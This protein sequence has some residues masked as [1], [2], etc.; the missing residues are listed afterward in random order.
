MLTVG[1]IVTVYIMLFVYQSDVLCWRHCSLHALFTSVYRIYELTRGGS[2]CRSA[3]L[4]AGLP[5]NASIWG[6]LSIGIRP[7]P[8]YDI[9]NS[10]VP[11]FLEIDLPDG[12]RFRNWGVRQRTVRAASLVVSKRTHKLNIFQEIAYECVSAN[13]VVVGGGD[14]SSQRT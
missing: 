2:I 11:I 13:G 12:I 6:R 4:C 5:R 8:H 9:A 3:G 7:F 10:V 1:A 14:E